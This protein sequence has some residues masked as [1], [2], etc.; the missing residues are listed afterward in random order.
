MALAPTLP[1]RPPVSVDRPL[2]AISLML[3]FCLLA[4]LGDAVAKLLGDTIPV[5]QLVLIRFAGQALLLPFALPG[6]RAIVASPRLVRATAL[7]TVLHMVGI[8]T[9]FWSLQ[10]LPLADA[11]AIIFVMPFV[12]LA[13]GA[14]I[15]GETVG[16][17]R[18]AAAALGFAGTLM[19]VQPSFAEVGWPAFLPM[20]VAVVFAFF[21]FVTRSVAKEVD[22]VALQAVSGTIATVLA[23][24]LVA[25]AIAFG[26]MEWVWPVRADAWLM[27]VIAVI[28]TL[29]HLLL[30]W[31][32]RHAPASTLAPMQYLE[33]PF[34]TALGWAI[35]SDLPNGL[36]AVGIAVTVAAGLAVIWFE[37][38]NAVHAARELRDGPEPSGASAPHPRNEAP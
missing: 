23:G 34:A 12:I 11:V 7:R 27:V 14:F 13:L 20:V 29:S 16:P 37:R 31:S 32:L 10:Y 18:V 22:A 28:G 8:G 5:L 19:V 2:F 4:P 33:I 30:T 26:W 17:R 38:E 3:G 1:I 6:S 25:G 15:Y 21:M 24:A 9:L 35:F 36:A